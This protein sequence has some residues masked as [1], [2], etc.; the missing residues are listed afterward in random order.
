MMKCTMIQL[1]DNFSYNYD[2]KRLL[3]HLIIGYKA[4]NCKVVMMDEGIIMYNNNGI[5]GLL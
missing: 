5:Q 4:I 1:M 2:K 3:E